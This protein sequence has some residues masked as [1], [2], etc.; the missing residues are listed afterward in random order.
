MR[1]LSEVVKFNPEGS[2]FCAYSENKEALQNFVIS[3]KNACEDDA[4]IQ[5]LFSM[6]ELD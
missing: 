4:L 2:M 5:D 6:A 3:F 1:A